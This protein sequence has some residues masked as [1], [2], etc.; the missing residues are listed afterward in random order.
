[1]TMLFAHRALEDV[2]THVP[3]PNDPYYY[4]SKVVF[5]NIGNYNDVRKRMKQNGDIIEG[6]YRLYAK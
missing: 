5:H 2:Q 6:F 4:G 1:M 3:L